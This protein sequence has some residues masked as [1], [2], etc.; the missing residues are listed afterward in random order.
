MLIPLRQ[1]YLT[2]GFKPTTHTA[3]DLGFWRLGLTTPDLFAWEDGVV[4]KSQYE[5]GG[6]NTIDIVHKDIA[7]GQWF[8]TNYVHLH[9]RALKVGDVVKKGQ[10]IGKAGNTGVNSTGPHLHFEVW[11]TPAG[12][13]KRYADRFKYC[14]DPRFVSF[15]SSDT[16][17]TGEGVQTV[18]YIYDKTVLAVPTT[19]KL[20]L[21]SMPAIVEATKLGSYVPKGGLPYLGSIV[22]NG[23]NWALLNFDGKIAYASMQYLTINVPKET[24]TQI[25]TKLVEFDIE[26][27]I[28]GGKVYVK[29]IAD[30]K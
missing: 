5:T 30:G 4:T 11:I 28:M 3:I 22:V 29:V 19:D 18:T 21:R 15:N 16:R 1:A 25:V 20:L 23:V 27:P 6:G 8:Y 17:V 14:I 10:L 13:V 26:E 7:P 2:Q 24:V 12:Y 9:T